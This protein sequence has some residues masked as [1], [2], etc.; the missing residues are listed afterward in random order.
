MLRQ[1]MT[2]QWDINSNPATL[3]DVRK[4]LEGFAKSNGMAEESSHAVGLVVNEALANIIRH[5]YGG[6]P[7]KPIRITAQTGDKE[8]KIQIRDWAKPFDPAMIK[9]RYDDELKPGGLGLICIRKLMDDARF[10]RLPDGMLL[11]LTKKMV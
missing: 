2:K 1:L 3:R 4:E 5:G 11:T 9:Q 6:A 10:E 7:D 8:L